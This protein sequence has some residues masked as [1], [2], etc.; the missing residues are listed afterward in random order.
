MRLFDSSGYEH[1]VL[2]NVQA[3]EPTHTYAHPLA[4][5]APR[6][7]LI[8]KIIV[9]VY[10]SYNAYKLNGCMQEHHCDESDL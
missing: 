1:L 8:Q 7:E 4:S 2:G 6:S 10:M 3:L 9:Y 5:K